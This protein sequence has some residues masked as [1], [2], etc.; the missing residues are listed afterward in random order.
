MCARARVC[1]IVAVFS[2]WAQAR[3]L[4]GRRLVAKFCVDHHEGLGSHT[5]PTARE[6]CDGVHWIASAHAG[7]PSVI[8]ILGFIANLAVVHLGCSC[9]GTELLVQYLHGRDMVSRLSAQCGVVFG[10]AVVLCCG[11]RAGAQLR[12]VG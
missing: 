10:D 9:G 2:F 5:M 4:L 6:S 7:L 1:V 11:A 12:A 3:V 8:A